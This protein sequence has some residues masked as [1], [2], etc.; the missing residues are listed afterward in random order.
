[1]SVSLSVSNDKHNNCNYIIK[2]MLKLGIN[3]RVI[4]SVSVVEDNIEKGFVIT[5]DSEF[6]DKKKLKNLWNC[7]KGDDY[8]CC[9]IL[10]SW[11]I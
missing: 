7:L 5:V 1:M 11:F 8:I 2:K 4:E 9:N 6:Y 10:Y 3:C